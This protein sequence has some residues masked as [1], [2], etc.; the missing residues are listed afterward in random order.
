MRDNIMIDSDKMAK[1]A[2]EGNSLDVLFSCGEFTI[3]EIIEC[4]P[5]V[6]AAFVPIDPI[7]RGEV[8]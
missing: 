2:R 6:M 5:S 3:A 4:L 8:Q 7:R 1:K